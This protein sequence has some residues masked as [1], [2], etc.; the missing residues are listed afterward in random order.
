MRDQ[1]RAGTRR[2][3][4]NHPVRT[5]LPGSGKLIARLRAIALDLPA[6]EEKLS[7]GEPTFFVTGG[8]MFVAVDNGHH[9]S[10]HVAIWCRAEPGVQEALVGGEPEHFFVPPY[11]G[12]S[13]WIGVRLD[14]GLAW[15][16][17]ALLVD[18]AWRLGAPKK[19]LAT[20]EPVPQRAPHP[21]FRRGPRK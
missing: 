14:S 1:A 19:L 4:S 21:R 9:G 16:K 3:S 18:A 7:H 12:K 5:G 17:V 15:E 6:A 2:R 8:K 10:G 11:V 20:L 13:G